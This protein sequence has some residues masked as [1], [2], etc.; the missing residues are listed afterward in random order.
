MTSALFR[1][2]RRRHHYISLYMKLAPRWFTYRN[3]ALAG[4]ALVVFGSALSAYNRHGI[5]QDEVQ[6]LTSAVVN[7]MNWLI[8]VMLLCTHSI[9]NAVRSLK[10]PAQEKPS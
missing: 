1:T 7:A 10:K 6:A 3:V 2:T 4:I 9:V 5:R 8:I